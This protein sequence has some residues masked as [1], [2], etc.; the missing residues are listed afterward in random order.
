M[1]FQMKQKLFALGSDFVIRDDDERDRYFVDGKAL[2]L[3]AK[4]SFQDME[5]RELA[6]I[7]QKLLAWGPT[8]EIFRDGERAAVV[9]KELFTF[10][11][12]TFTVDVP[13]PDDLMAEGNFTDHEYVFQRG[14]RVVASVSKEWFAWS[15]SYGVD[16]APG[17]D[18]VLI[19]AS[20]V[21]IDMACHPTGKH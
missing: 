14:E 15:D 19:L 1:R 3:G 2:S 21:V 17:E 13:G 5:G 8:Y 4:L 9:T 12:C 10:F 11:R 6:F 7:Q 20:T 18:P 16:L